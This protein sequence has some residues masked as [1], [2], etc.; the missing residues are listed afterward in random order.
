MPPC[1]QRHL[2]GGEPGVQP[3]LPQLIRYQLSGLLDRGR[4]G[5]GHGSVLPHARGQASRYFSCGIPRSHTAP[6]A[7]AHV[8]TVAASSVT[9][10]P[11]GE[12]SP[13]PVK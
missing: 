1:C 13:S 3:D 6:N 5:D 8:L 11:S 10:R 9:S 7:A 4:G 12:T 2:P